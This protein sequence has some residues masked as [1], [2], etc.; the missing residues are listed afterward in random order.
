MP[1]FREITHRSA[2]Y[3]QTAALRRAVLLDPF[4]IKLTEDEWNEESG[5]LHFGLFE[6]SRLIACCF[7]S[8]MDGGTGKLRQMAVAPDRQ[9]AGCGQQLLEDVEG[10][11]DSHGYEH[12]IMDARKPAVG[13]YHRLGYRITSDEFELVGIPHYRMEKP[14]APESEPAVIV[15]LGGPN[16]PDGAL[17]PIARQRCERA[18]AERHRHLDWPILPTGG[19]G[20]HFNQAPKPHGFYTSQYL[21]DQGVDAASILPVAESSHT[22][23]DADKARPILEATGLKRL[24]LVTS[25]FHSQRAGRVFQNTFPDWR[26]HLSCSLT[27][28]PAAELARLRAH[29]AKALHRFR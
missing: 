16:E 27:E 26:I 6:Q 20:E 15:L 13:F 23:D 21:I 7:V 14:L 10:S 12:V 3:E 8:P 4:D 19:F 18:L 25:E 28:L 5:F 24:I 29:E 9:G 1:T 2:E 22:R 11:L 17:S